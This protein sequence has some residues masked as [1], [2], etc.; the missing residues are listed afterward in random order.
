LGKLKSKT[1]LI[2]GDSL[3]FNPRIYTPT[4]G[5]EF[6]FRY[7]ILDSDNGDV[8]ID[9][10]DV[11]FI[12]FLS[13]ENPTID[14]SVYPNPANDV[15]NITISEN[16]TSIVL[17]DVVGKNV[18]EME[19]INGNNTLNIENLDAGVYFYSIKRNGVSIETKQL[20]V[21]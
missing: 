3:I 12:S 20:I 16:N 11:K 5:G 13:I 2:N 19:L 8:M 15:L 10:V 18:S 7:Y 6:H 4:G 9:S 14:F 17:F 1:L 21:K